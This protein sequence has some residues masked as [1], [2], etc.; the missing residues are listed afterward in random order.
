MREFGR[1]HA[2]LHDDKV[3]ND[4]EETQ[5]QSAKPVVFRPP[6]IDDVSRILVSFKSVA[7]NLHFPRRGSESHKNLEDLVGDIASI[8]LVPR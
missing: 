6:S 1:D 5:Q 8:I 7:N 4:E 3:T 2:G